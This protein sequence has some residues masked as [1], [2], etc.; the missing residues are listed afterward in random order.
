MFRKSVSSFKKQPTPP[1]TGEYISRLLKHAAPA[2]A[3]IR[4]VTQSRKTHA[5]SP[6]SHTSDQNDPCVTLRVQLGLRASY[7]R[8]GGAAPKKF[9]VAFKSQKLQESSNVFY[10]LSSHLFLFPFTFHPDPYFSL[11]SL[12]SGG[13]TAVSHTKTHLAIPGRASPRSCKVGSSNLE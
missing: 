7:K 1:S 5:M 2:P 11:Y 12:P 3:P 8:K 4:L 10:F 6:E 9:S 13:S